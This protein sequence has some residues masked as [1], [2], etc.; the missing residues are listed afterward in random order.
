MDAACGDGAILGPPGNKLIAACT[1]SSQPCRRVFRLGSR[2]RLQGLV[3]GNLPAPRP[4]SHSPD[5]SAGM[6]VHAGPG[7]PEPGRFFRIAATFHLPVCCKSHMLGGKRRL[8]LGNGDER[9]A[10]HV[11]SAEVRKLTLRRQNW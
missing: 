7:K 9:I 4:F 3:D 6:L 2:G 1:G 11:P 8:W 10:W 5:T